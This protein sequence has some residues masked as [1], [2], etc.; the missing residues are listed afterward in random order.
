MEDVAHRRDGF[1]AWVKADPNDTLERHMVDSRKSF[2][3]YR[4]ASVRRQEAPAQEYSSTSVCQTVHLFKK[5]VSFYNWNPGLQRGKEGAIEKQIAGN[6]H[7]ETW[8]EAIEYVEQVPRD[9][10][11]RMRGAPQQGHFLP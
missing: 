9:P 7:I 6:W 11:R 10:L 2:A 8:Q 1:T 3:E 4:E 5:R